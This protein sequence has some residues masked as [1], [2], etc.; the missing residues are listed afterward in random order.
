MSDVGLHLFWEAGGKGEKVNKKKSKK[1]SRDHELK[2]KNLKRGFCSFKSEI[3]DYTLSWNYWQTDA[4][5]FSSVS[6]FIGDDI[7]AFFVTWYWF[8]SLFSSNTHIKA[9][10]KKLLTAFCSWPIPLL[11]IRLTDQET[12]VE[13]SNWNPLLSWAILSDLR[14][15]P[16]LAF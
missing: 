8:S 6:V 5:S 15:C 1:K 16:Q 7:L 4:L 13:I 12:F 10:N 3:T 11:S 2:Q 9:L 14:Y